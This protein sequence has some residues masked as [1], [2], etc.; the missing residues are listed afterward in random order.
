MKKFLAIFL[1]SQSGPKAEAWNAMDP[2]QRKAREKA[3]MEGW[4]QFMETHQACFVDPGGP[5]GKTKVVSEQG[6]AD[7]RNNM[8]AYT[9]IEA[10]SHEAAASI[11]EQHPHFTH[12]PGDAVEIMEI[13]PIPQM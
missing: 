8:S 12:F 4:F 5:L 9:I 1:G 10:E 13:M 6:I 2:E 7:T 3:G 11:F